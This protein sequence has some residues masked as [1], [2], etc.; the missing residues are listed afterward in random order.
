MNY[1]QIAILL[2]LATFSTFF[3]QSSTTIEYF[4]IIGFRLAFFL[5]FI[6]YFS[7]EFS[8]IVNKQ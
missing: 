3:A 5:L 7:Q 6:K 2:A 1:W 4:F 8:R